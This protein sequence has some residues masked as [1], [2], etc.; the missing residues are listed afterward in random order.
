MRAK[1][2]ASEKHERHKN[3]RAFLCRFC[4]AF[5]FPP[6]RTSG[7]AN[8]SAGYSRRQLFANAAIAASRVGSYLCIGQRSS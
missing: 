7:L 5:P 3:I 6:E 2:M 4:A 8:G 1:R